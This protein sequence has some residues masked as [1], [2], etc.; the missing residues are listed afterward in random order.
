V[1]RVELGEVGQPA[2]PAVDVDGDEVVIGGAAGAR[3]RLPASLAAPCHVRLARQ[4]DGWRWTAAAAVEVDGVARQ[5]GD[6]GP[7]GEALRLVIG[8][9]QLRIT[10]APADVAPTPPIRTESLARELVR[11]LLGGEGAPTL[12]IE[13]GPGVGGRRVIPPPEARLVIGRGDEADWVL[14][15]EDLS[16]AH[17]EIRRDWDGVRVRDLDSKNG[18]VV[19]GAAA[20]P[21]GTRLVDGALIELGPVALRFH[22]PAERHLAGVAPATPTSVTPTLAVAA[23]PI[24]LAP[25]TTAPAARPA[26]FYA[27]V[28]VA[29]VALIGL[30][31]LLVT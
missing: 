7:L 2:L 9:Y 10:A 18:T 6:G 11:G 21:A 28:A 12:A 8:R 29:G 15:D 16:R 20:A 23:A 17:A 14:A 1:L 24:A 26:A 30:G 19:D 5:V 4:V 13:R 27:A 3:I 31:W 22:D 25:A